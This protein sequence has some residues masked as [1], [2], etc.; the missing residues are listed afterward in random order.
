MLSS[1][2]VAGPCPSPHKLSKPPTNR[3]STNLLGATKQTQEQP[4]PV[5]SSDADSTEG[6]FT[7]TAPITGE[8]RPRRNTRSKI[9]SYLYGQNQDNGQVHHSSEDDE[10]SPKSFATVVKRRLSRADSSPLLQGPSLGTSPASSASRLFLAGSAGSDLDEEEVTKEQI[11]EKVWTD[12]LAAQNH[13][14]SPVDEEK[15]P[16]SVMTPI[17]RRSLYT[18][19]IATRSPQD[20]LRKPPVPT[21]VISQAERDYYYNP[22]MPESSPLSLLALLRASNNGRSTPSELDYTHLGAMKLGTLRVT[23]GAASPIPQDRNVSSD[24][25]SNI[26]TASG[27]NCYAAS[28][29]SKNE[30]ERSADNSSVSVDLP[31]ALDGDSADRV[32]PLSECASSIGPRLTCL[33]PS[34]RDRIPSASPRPHQPYNSD[35]SDPVTGHE[36]P[37]RENTI[38]RKPLPPSAISSRADPA[39]SVAM[40]SAA[41]SRCDLGPRSDVVRPAQMGLGSAQSP[42]DSSNLTEFAPPNMRNSIPDVWRAFIHAAEERHADSGSRQ[43]AYFKL[44]GS[45]KS[46]QAGGDIHGMLQDRP[47]NYP[48]SRAFHH[49]DSGYN[50]NTSLESAESA[51]IPYM[52]PTHQAASGLGEVAKASAQEEFHGDFFQG[53]RDNDPTETPI[54]ACPRVPGIGY[55]S[56]TNTAWEGSSIVSEKK[57]LQSNPPQRHLPSPEKSRKL[58][59]RRPKSQPPLQR[60]P[61]SADDVSAYQQIPP[62]PPAIADTHS[63]RMNHFPSLD[64]TPPGLQHT[65]SGTLATGSNPTPSDIRFPSPTHGADDSAIRDQSLFRKL[66]SRARSQSRSIPR[67]K[68]MVCQSDEES[69]KSD[70]MRS[71][72]WSDY[73][74]KKKKERKAKEKA[75]RELQERSKR[76]SSADRKSDM[77]STSRFRSRS[78]ARSSHREPIPTLTDF[79]TVSESL[80]RGPYD[81]AKSNIDGERGTAGTGLQPHQISPD[82]PSTQRI[83]GMFEDGHAHDRYRSRSIVRHAVAENQKKGVTV[84]VRAKPSRP[85]SM[86]VGADRPPVP[87]LPVANWRA[88]TCGHE[89][90]MSMDAGLHSAQ[91]PYGAAPATSMVDLT[92]RD[93]LQQA[94]QSSI[95]DEISCSLVEG[96]PADKVVSMEELI[97]KLLDA[98]DAETKETILHQMRQQRRAL[99]GGSAATRQANA[100]VATKTPM[101]AEAPRQSIQ[102]RNSD[103]SL[104]RIA[105]T[106][107]APD[108]SLEIEDGHRSQGMF[109][110]APP[111]PPLPSAERLQQHEARKSVSKTEHSRTLIPP[112]RRAPEPPKPDLW[113]G[114]A[115]ETE[116]KKAM[117]QGVPDWG[118]HQQAWSQRRRS[119]GE[120]LLS[121]ARP[122]GHADGSDEADLDETSRERAPQP[123]IHRAQTIGLE[124]LCLPHHE[125]KAFHKPWGETHGQDTTPSNT[126]SSSQPDS[127][128]AAAAQAF[129]R[130]SGRYEGGLQYGVSQ[131]P[132]SSRPQS[133][134]VWRAVRAVSALSTY[135]PLTEGENANSGFLLV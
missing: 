83:E 31:Q 9:R 21:T 101:N 51:Q 19:G 40:D 124:P 92:P 93:G 128:V 6:Y 23:N 47:I 135:W 74:N 102:C 81:V 73:G 123:I 91:N 63:E 111:M 57:P 45:H 71:P 132:S 34:T 36:L 14:S 76:E 122:S 116:H 48:Q 15:H 72:S 109:A 90:R 82:K 3:S 96:A 62:V 110:D 125:S 68:H 89:G 38:R 79:G 10:S 100:S 99:L 65:T 86:F 84:N 134:P 130:R 69:D 78:R 80:G 133:P 77:R 17:R 50:S 106:S 11:K 105:I 131:S 58:Q 113:A 70:I 2:A 46:E 95:P 126:G 1:L 59:K 61:A 112:Q 108:T 115:M 29:G 117:I 33:D 25:L 41:D 118:S 64:C 24:P 20:I 52:S 13:V 7:Q 120:A 119:A 129:E 94:R 26:A 4:S 54:A 28:A 44:T 5:I 42:G 12:T 60:I 66:A 16:D 49:G 53:D 121:K 32:A 35:H 114:C 22:T 67:E 27:E 107:K 98:P 87:A 97:D 85:H 43:D 104:A 127:Q 55:G 103:P 56:A 75:E 8:R 30:E 88:R 39:T 37:V 18:P